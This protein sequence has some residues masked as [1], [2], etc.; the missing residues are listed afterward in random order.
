MLHLASKYFFFISGWNP[1]FSLLDALRVA[2]AQGRGG[3]GEGIY[4]L[5]FPDME[6]TGNLVNL[7]FYTGKIL[8][9]QHSAGYQSF[10]FPTFKGFSIVFLVLS[11]L[12]QYRY[13][14]AVL[15]P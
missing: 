3:G 1:F 6:N 7:I 10:L 12:W 2:T 14:S 4:M 11:L 9:T 5:S 13:F 8:A 15:G